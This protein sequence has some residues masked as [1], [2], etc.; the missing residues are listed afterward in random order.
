M[1]D[2]MII[3]ITTSCDSVTSTLW[4]L[5]VPACTSSDDL[6]ERQLWRTNVLSCCSW[7]VM[8][9]LYW[10]QF[11][12]Q[13]IVASSSLLA[14]ACNIIELIAS[15]WLHYCYYS[16]C[17]NKW[18]TPIFKST[19]CYFTY[20]VVTKYGLA[21]V[22]TIVFLLQQSSRALC[23]VIQIGCYVTCIRLTLRGNYNCVV[24]S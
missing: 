18:H 19:N 16:C 21:I 23:C 12:D 20:S 13:L 15:W 22:Y 10:H 1:L 2:V 9:T 7:C 17:Q 14:T 4:D 6:T 8:T 5:L 11:T 3:L 24:F